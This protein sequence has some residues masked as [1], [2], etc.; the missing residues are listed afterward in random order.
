MVRQLLLFY[1]IY[2]QDSIL[3]SAF[4]SSY[5]NFKSSHIP[6]YTLLQSMV[7]FLLLHH[8]MH[9]YVWVYINKPKTNCEIY[10]VLHVCMSSG[11]ILCSCVLF[12]GE[13]YLSC[14]HSDLILCNFCRELRSHGISPIQFDV[15]FDVLP[16]QFIFGYNASRILHLY[17]LILL[18]DKKISR[19]FSFPMTLKIF[20]PYFQNVPWI[21]RIG[22][23]CTCISIGPGLHNSSH[24]L[25]PT[26]IT[27]R[28]IEFY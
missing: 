19:K 16:L 26:V 12:F 27:K 20:S 24:S 15:S 5:L 13:E 1:S 10:L 18:E 25:S 21:L 14:S 8:F 4:F 17:P 6:H 23:L 22:M 9:M 28:E 3:I 7:Y 11:K 2:L